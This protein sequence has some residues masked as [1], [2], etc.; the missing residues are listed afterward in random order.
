MVVSVILLAGFVGHALAGEPP[1]IKKRFSTVIINKNKLDFSKTNLVY[2]EIFLNKIGDTI[3]ARVTFPEITADQFELAKVHDAYL[4]KMDHPRL[5]LTPAKY[6][7]LF[8]LNAKKGDWWNAGDVFNHLKCTI[9]FEDRIIDRV[10]NETL[11]VFNITG[12]YATSHSDYISKLYFS[13]EKGIVRLD[14]GRLY[15]GGN[16]EK[17][18]SISHDFVK[19]K[20]IKS[21]LTK[22]E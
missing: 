21:Y 12:D 11:Y 20:N 4:M 17:A 10:T 6:Q 22:L 7:L 8:D 3:F 15:L 16:G 9:T 13:R 5:K 14:F 19:K 18:V 2:E 1:K